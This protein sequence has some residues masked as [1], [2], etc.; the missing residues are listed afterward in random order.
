MQAIE[1]NVCITSRAKINVDMHD[2]VLCT[3]NKIYVDMHDLVLC[4]QNKCPY[5]VRNQSIAGDTMI[6]KL[7]NPLMMISCPPHTVYT[8]VGQTNALFLED[9]VT[10]HKS[11]WIAFEYGI[12]SLSVSVMQNNMIIGIIKGDI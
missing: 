8:N 10:Q 12:L 6:Y 9:C 7:L 11:P 5:T 2:L 4:A 3:Q 1:D